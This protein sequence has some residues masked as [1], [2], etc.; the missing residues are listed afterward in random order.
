ML[1]CDFNKIRFQHGFFSSKFP[2]FF[3]APVHKNTS[4]GLLSNKTFYNKIQTLFYKFSN[5]SLS[6]INLEA[7]FA[8]KLWA[9]VTEI[10]CFLIFIFFW[11]IFL[12][13]RFHISTSFGVLTY[14]KLFPSRSLT[15]SLDW[16]W[17]DTL[18]FSL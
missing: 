4:G 2:E 18:A 1:K 11:F 8:N 14:W 6:V 17:A 3:R 16:H 9:F 7:F 15:N 5:I 12:L 13:T 10:W